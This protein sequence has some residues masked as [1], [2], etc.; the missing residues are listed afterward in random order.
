MFTSD[1]LAG[2]VDLFGALTRSELEAALSE[3][4]Y[5]RGEEPRDGNPIDRALEA[6]ALVAVE[7]DE[8]AD[9]GGDSGDVDRGDGG[10]VGEGNGVDEPLLAPGPAAFPTLPEGADDLPHIL[11]IEERSV[12]RERV[13]RAAEERLRAA[14]ARAVA[15]GDD[16]RV[17][18]L[19]DVSYDIEAWA[20]VDL[21]GV[22]ARLDAAR[23]TQE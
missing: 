13:G 16:S 18:E 1:D 17:V 11:D 21:A 23:E 6:F 10:D 19:Q 7:P 4:A 20:G 9:H 8:D 2:V 22:R 15:D 12:P 5:R 3:L 14:A